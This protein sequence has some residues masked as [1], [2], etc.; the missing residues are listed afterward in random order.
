MSDCLVFQDGEE[1]FH[2]TETPASVQQASGRTKG[3]AWTERVQVGGLS[4]AASLHR[5]I[6]EEALPA[7]GV[8]PQAFWDGRRRD[9]PRPRAAQP[10]A[11]RPARRAADP[12]RRLPPRAPRRAR[13]GDLHRLPARD[14]LPA[15]R[16]GRGRGEHRQR[17]RR[18]GPHRRPAAGRPAAQRA[19][20]HQRRQ[21]PL[22]LA[23]RRPLRLR[24][25]PAGGRPRPRGRLQQGPRRRGHRPWPGLPRRALPAG[26]RARTPTPRRTPWTAR[27]SP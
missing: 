2:N 5:F 13:R 11:A 26:L 12:H 3:V 4:V 16:A 15:R 22:G 19:V 18:G 10:R 9:H 6:E 23:V 14:R 7:A 27:G 25:G 21:R 24:R 20:R 17:R 1:H 8:D